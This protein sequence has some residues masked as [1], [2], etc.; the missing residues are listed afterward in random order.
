VQEKLFGKNPDLSSWDIKDQLEN[1]DF[2]QGQ[3]LT[4]IQGAQDEMNLVRSSAVIA[5][6]LQ[7]NSN[8]QWKLFPAEGAKLFREK[9]LGLDLTNIYFCFKIA[10]RAIKK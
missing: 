6:A 3:K 4:V 7:Q 8:F 1:I 9:Y 5:E 2:S 10:F